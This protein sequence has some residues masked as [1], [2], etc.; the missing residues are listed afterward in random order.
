MIWS[1]SFNQRGTYY[2]VVEHAGKGQGPS[3]YLLE[4]DGGGVSS[5]VPT[6]AADSAPAPSS[7][8]SEKTPMSK[9]AGRLAFQTTVGG[10]LYTVNVDGR[11]LQRVADGMDPT[12]SPDGS[13]IAFNRWR[14]PRGVWVAKADGSEQRRIFDWSEPRWISWSP[15]GSQ[16]MFSRVTGGRQEPREFCFRGFC[17]TFPANPH[18]VMG[19]V[20]PSDGSFYEPPPPDSRTSRAPDW[21]PTAEQ[22]VFADVK[23][24]RIQT[25][26]GAV[27]YLV[28]SDSR[29]ISPTW[30]PD[31]RR[32][33]FV[34]RQHDHW[35]IYSV[36][37]DGGNLRRLTV[38]PKR[39]DGSFADNASPAWSPDGQ[40]I[41]FLTDR[42]GK[43]EIWV[44]RA[45]GSQ[46]RPMFATALDGLPLEY[47]HL[48]ERA[49]SWTE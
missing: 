10:D 44:M 45:D 17:F 21:H 5:S 35:E 26:D 27:S 20:R 18:W 43:W 42:T 29:D 6:A 49:I 32:V 23:G 30:S 40:H 25:L 28:T 41:A 7:S 48:G 33:A 34:R 16:V 13:Q 39:A 12:W 31:G 47:T 37:F 22:V 4:I 38:A 1:G 9:P 2:V 24:L 19:I 14:E 11:G 3:Y 36:G 8:K 15:D 46:P